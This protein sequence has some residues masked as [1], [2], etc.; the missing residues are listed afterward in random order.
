[1]G[2]LWG[3]IATGAFAAVAICG[4]SGLFEGNVQQ[5]LINNFAALTALVFSFVVTYL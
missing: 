5:F 4:I 2:G 3:T 1:M